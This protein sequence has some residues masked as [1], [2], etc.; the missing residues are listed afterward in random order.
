MTEILKLRIERDDGTHIVRFV[1]MVEPPFK[2]M[3]KPQGKNVRA[4]FHQGAERDGTYVYRERR[5]S[6]AKGRGRA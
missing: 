2:V 1:D 3:F 5:K 4:Y 6:V